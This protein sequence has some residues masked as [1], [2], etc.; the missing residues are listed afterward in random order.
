MYLRWM[1]KLQRELDKKEGML[2]S[3]E[4]LGEDTSEDEEQKEPMMEEPTIEEE[5]KG[6][7]TRRV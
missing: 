2:F 7:M 1:Y 5:P 6:L 3:E 4:E